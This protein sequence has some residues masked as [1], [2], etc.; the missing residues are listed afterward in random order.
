MLTGQE[1]ARKDKVK[2]A[3]KRNCKETV[4]Q[5]KVTP[6]HTVNECSE[7]IRLNIILIA[8]CIFPHC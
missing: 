2:S 8:K 7:M 4:L 6:F 1:N 3:R 5:V